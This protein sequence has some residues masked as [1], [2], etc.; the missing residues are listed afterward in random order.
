MIVWLLSVSIRYGDRV[1]SGTAAGIILMRKVRNQ[2]MV[3]LVK[4]PLYKWTE[5][6]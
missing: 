5:R 1:S 2:L 4:I 6:R 3:P